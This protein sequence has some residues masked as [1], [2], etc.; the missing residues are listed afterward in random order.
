MKITANYRFPYDGRFIEK[1]QEIDVPDHDADILVILN[2]ARYLTRNLQTGL[3]K[4]AVSRQRSPRIITKG[5]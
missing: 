4:N 3:E 2:H 5:A 1:D